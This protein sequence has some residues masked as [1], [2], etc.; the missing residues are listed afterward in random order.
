MCPDGRFPTD[1]ITRRADRAAHFRHRTG[2]RFVTA[3]DSSDMH[4]AEIFIPMP[5]TGSIRILAAFETLLG[6]L[7]W[8]AG[9][10]RNSRHDRQ[11]AQRWR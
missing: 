3:Q 9:Q 11:R 2:S 7:S 5:V 4:K 6:M 1:T 8:L 10:I